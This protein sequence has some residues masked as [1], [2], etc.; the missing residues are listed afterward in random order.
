MPTDMGDIRMGLYYLRVE[1]ASI[2]Y[3]MQSVQAECRKTVFPHRICCNMG[4]G[5]HTALAA[6]RSLLEASNL[7]CSTREAIG[8]VWASSVLAL[9]FQVCYQIPQKIMILKIFKSATKGSVPSIIVFVQSLEGMHFRP[10][11]MCADTIN[12]AHRI[13]YSL[14]KYFTVASVRECTCSFS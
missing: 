2:G 13:H 3:G 12:G 5:S 14:P 11:W 4:F 6:W 9:P 8:K 7:I 1:T 10:P